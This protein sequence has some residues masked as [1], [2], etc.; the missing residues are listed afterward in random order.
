MRR[1][2][3]PA[4]LF[5]AITPSSSC[6]EAHERRRAV[7]LQPGGQRVQVDAGAAHRGQH[8]LAVAAVGRRRRADR[9]W[10]AKAFSVPSG[11]VL[12]VKGAASAS[13]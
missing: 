9:P 6:H 8:G 1:T 11:M 5:E 13:T 4:A 10:S 12:T 7:A 3:L 2:G